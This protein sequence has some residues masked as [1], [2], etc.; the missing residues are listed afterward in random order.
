MLLSKANVVSLSAIYSQKLFTLFLKKI[1]KYLNLGF[2]V[3]IGANEV[4][5]MDRRGEAQ[6]KATVLFYVVVFVHKSGEHSAETLHI[7]IY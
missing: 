7:N 5:Q 4:R 6:K 2:I 1:E 3:R